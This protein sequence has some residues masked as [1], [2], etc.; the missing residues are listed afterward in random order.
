MDWL[1]VLRIFELLFYY[2]QYAIAQV[3]VLNDV[4]EQ[5]RKR[6]FSD[7]WIGLNRMR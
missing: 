6:P 7:V 1:S 4:N 3:G 2:I 5:K